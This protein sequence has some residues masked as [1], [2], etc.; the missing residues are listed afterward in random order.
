MNAF[1]SSTQ[2]YLRAA[3]S[4]QYNLILF[5]G[6]V[7]FSAALA[8]W[9]PLVSGLVGEAV[10]LLTGPRLPAFR[11]RTD[12]LEDKAGSV[13]IMEALGPEYLERVAVLERDVVEVQEL[14]ASRADVSAEQGAEVARRLRP[15][16]QSFLDVCTTHQRLRRVAAQAPVAELQAELSTLHQALASETDLGVRASLR[17]ALSVAERRIKQLEGNEAAARSLELALQTLHKSVALFKEAAAGLGTVVELCAEIDAAT[18]QLGRAAALH[19]EREHEV[20][21]G[22]AS[23][24]PPPLN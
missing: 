5:A 9:A 3:F 2:K 19:A 13:R 16:V 4:N 18:A 22:R 14:C 21:V 12:A 6:S 1:E 24:L 23:T 15:M 10:W 17:R 8:S 11:R 20:S 7:S